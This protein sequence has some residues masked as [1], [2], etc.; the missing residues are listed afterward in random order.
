MKKVFVVE[1]HF[2]MREMLRMLVARTPSL[3]MCGEAES[4][5]KA[6]QEIPTAAPDIVLI[7]V[8]LPRMNGIELA[9]HILADRP[10]LPILFISGHDESVYAEQ[11]YRLGARGYTTKGDPM[12]IMTA[13]RNVIEGKLCFKRHLLALS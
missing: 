5:E 1:D 13:L 6:L 8:S 4:A 12:A 3:E 2:T 7:D 11:A 9:K 10:D